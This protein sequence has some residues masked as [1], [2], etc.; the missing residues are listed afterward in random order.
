MRL[1]VKTVRPLERSCKLD[2]DR[3]P[4]LPIDD[5]DGGCDCETTW[6]KGDPY[7][8]TRQIATLQM[9]SRDNRLSAPSA[10]ALASST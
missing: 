5:K 2:P 4:P 9:K 10:R 6:K 1:P 8:W 3:E 7:P